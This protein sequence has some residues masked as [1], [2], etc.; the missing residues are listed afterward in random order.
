MAKHVVQLNTLQSLAGKLGFAAGAVPQL[1]PFLNPLWA[2]T[3]ERKAKDTGR[4]LVHVK[5]ISTA[6]RSLLAFLQR[7]PGAIVRTHHAA[8]VCEPIVQIV[9]DASP[10]GIG[11]N[12]AKRCGAVI[13]RSDYTTT[14]ELL[15]I[16]VALRSWAKAGT[17]TRVAVKSDSLSACRAFLKT[18]YKSPLLAPIARELAIDMALQCYQITEVVHIPGVSNTVADALSRLHAPEPKRLPDAVKGLPQSSVQTRDEN[19]WLTC[20]LSNKMKR[21]SGASLGIFRVP[22]RVK[23]PRLPGPVA[24]DQPVAVGNQGGSAAGNSCPSSRPCHPV[25]GDQAVARGNQCQ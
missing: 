21:T 5:R 18:T 2:V 14:W 9:V 1:K 25:V 24:C 22:K 13:G 11:E 10:W 8:Q 3:A 19:F 7:V 16:L 4:Q 12:D 15:A 23:L 20:S 17:H 6:L